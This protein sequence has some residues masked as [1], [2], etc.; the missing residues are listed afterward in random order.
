[1]GVSLPDLGTSDASGVLAVQGFVIQ[2]GSEVA[3]G[4]SPAEKLRDEKA[5]YG[6]ARWRKFSTF[7]QI[8]RRPRP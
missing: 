5:K 8:S 3:R 4:K 2:A 1:M 6:L 7:S